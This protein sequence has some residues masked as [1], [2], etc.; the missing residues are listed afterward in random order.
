V[1]TEYLGQITGRV[2]T[3]DGAPVPRLTVELMQPEIPDFADASYR[4]RAITDAGGR[5]TIPGVVPGRY[6]PG[7][8]IAYGDFDAAHSGTEIRFAYVGDTTSKR[9][10]RR[11]EVDG[12][13]TRDAGTLVLPKDVRV[14]QVGGVVVRADGRP[15][16]GIKV[17]VKADYD[18][19]NLPWT[20]ILTNAR[21]RFTIGL[22][23]GTRYRLV[24]EAG[25]AGVSS[26]RRETRVTVDPVVG[27]APLRIVVP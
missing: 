17:R 2:T 12:G 23:A 8:A 27:M 20:T 16:A 14:V 24:A 21:G 15:A 11:V 7:V 26:D 3:A 6:V 18:D 19:W 1:W 13:T 4:Q 25:N 9:A 5:F 10:A 22:L